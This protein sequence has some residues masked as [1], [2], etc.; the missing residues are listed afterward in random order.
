[1]QLEL[2]CESLAI[3]KINFQWHLSTFTFRPALTQPSTS[4]FTML[5]PGLSVEV[6]ESSM[7]A[8]SSVSGCGLGF[9]FL[10]I[11]AMS[12]GGV[13]SGLP[14]A[15]S[16]DLVAQMLIGAGRL[17]QQTG[18]HPAQV[19][20]NLVEL[21]FNESL[22]LHLSG[23]LDG[24]SSCRGSRMGSCPNPLTYLLSGSENL[25]RLKRAV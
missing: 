25:Y 6:K 8:V 22:V 21:L 16:M 13:R 10:V 15:L 4:S 1:M 20:A 9:L 19:I 24:R 18:K 2:P 14:R 17:V 11:E 12:D 5:S 7:N 3:F 23:Q